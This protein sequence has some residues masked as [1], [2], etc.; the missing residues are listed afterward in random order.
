VL[1][2]VDGWMD[3]LIE[4]D[5]RRGPSLNCGGFSTLAHRFSRF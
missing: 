3:R 1:F 5:L 4:I 2:C